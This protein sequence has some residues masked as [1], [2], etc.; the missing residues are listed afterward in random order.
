MSL[1]PLLIGLDSFALQM[2]RQKLERI[3]IVKIGIVLAFLLYPRTKLDFPVLQRNGP[4]SS[5]ILV[6]Y[7]FMSLFLH[8]VK[9]SHPKNVRLSDSPP[10]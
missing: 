10:R 2:L 7:P 9:G 6:P 5:K 4:C 3:L 8:I 1:R